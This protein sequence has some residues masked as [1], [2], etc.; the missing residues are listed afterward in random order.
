[1]SDDE[2]RLP[3]EIAE[4]VFWLGACL[5]TAA[6]DNV[7]V[8]H[9]Y[10]SAFLVNGSERSI[11]IEAGHTIDWPVLDEQLTE[12][13]AAG[14]HEP[15]HLFVSHSELPHAG[16]IG[17]L[18]ERFPDAVGCG[19]VSDLHLVFPQFADRLLAMAD[20]DVIDLGDSEVGVHRGRFVDYPSTLWAFDSRRRVL[21]AGDGFAYAH[22]HAA[23]QCGH[24]A[25]EV[26]WL[27]VPSTTA[28]FAEAAF[29]WTRFVD[30]EPYID[31]LNEFVNA[32]LKPAIIAPTHGL[33]ITDPV[34]TFALVAEGLRRGGMTGA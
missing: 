28:M 15:S 16:C 4:G 7:T 13:I 9:A 33:P 2:P 32:E 19:D 11:L 21:F 30:I 18:L 23:G 14:A 8:V 12:V 25:E 3:R 22:F 29:F 10:D 24:V 1:M 17:H 27:D 26:P 34:E 20:A 31:A 6:F 5:P